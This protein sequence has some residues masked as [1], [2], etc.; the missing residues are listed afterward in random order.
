MK[1]WPEVYTEKTPVFNL[2]KKSY[3][4]M[5]RGGE[6]AQ[7]AQ[8]LAPPPETPRPVPST[9]SGDSQTPGSS[10]SRVSCLLLAPG[11]T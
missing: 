5:P 3:Y 8:A 10:S 2:K 1:A 9:M 6:A 11:D 4:R 7:Q